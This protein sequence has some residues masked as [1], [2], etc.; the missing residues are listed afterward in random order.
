MWR[1]DYNVQKVA[2]H[3]NSSFT[4]VGQF[5]RPLCLHGLNP[6]RRG[7]HAY[8]TRGIASRWDETST[9]WIIDDRPSRPVRIVPPHLGTHREYVH[10]DC[11]RGS[12]GRSDELLSIESIIGNGAEKVRGE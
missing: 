7:E 11:S 6:P 1:I 4:G 12:A 9:A 2:A 8:A 3:A 5:T 10:L